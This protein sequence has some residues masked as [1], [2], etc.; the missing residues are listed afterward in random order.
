MSAQEACVHK[1]G[2]SAQW[3]STHEMYLHLAGPFTY[4][5]P[6]ACLGQRHEAGNGLD[7][8]VPQCKREILTI[9]TQSVMFPKGPC[10]YMG[11]TW[12]LK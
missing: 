7:D 11:Y 2:K 10:S 3:I 5:E 1:A 9:C 4:P 8:Q 12:A 6:S